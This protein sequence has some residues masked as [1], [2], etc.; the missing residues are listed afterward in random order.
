MTS[1]CVLISFSRAFATAAIASALSLGFASSAFAQAAP[2]T[3][4]EKPVASEG[5]PVAAATPRPLTHES[6]L[7][8]ASASGNAESNTYNAKQVTS[9]KL[10]DDKLTFSA[11]Y[12]NTN[13]AGVDTARNWDGAVRFD[14]GFSAWWTL[15]AQFG[16]ESDFFAGFVQRNNHDIGTHYDF[17]K[18]N[19]TNFFAE[20]GYRYSYTQYTTAPGI[21]AAAHIIRL[22]VEGSQKIME[23]TSG[24]LWVEYLPS[25]N[26]PE[27]YR[28]NIE[29]SLVSQ[30]NGFLSLKVGYLIKYH[31]VITAPATTYSD[32]LFTTSLVAKF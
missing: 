24:R 5:A 2:S 17:V 21:S 3:Q 12:L 20:A 28:I 19:D 29:P 32:R 8:I 10:G 26:V 22:Y 9:Y 7:G 1:S 30:L 14:H 23:R 6:E 13:A 15:Y 4:T 11:R 16:L 31:N 18:S 27:D 25:V